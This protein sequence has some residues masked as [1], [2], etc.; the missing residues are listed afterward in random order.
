MACYRFPMWKRDLAKFLYDC[1]KI[2]LA[3]MVIAPLVTGTWIAPAVGIVGVI[4]LAWVATRLAQEAE[5][6]SD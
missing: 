6:A 5:D 2:M 4:V 1:A 3:G